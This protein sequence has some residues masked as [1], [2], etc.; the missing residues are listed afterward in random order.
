MN[1]GEIIRNLKEG[2][3]SITERTES[4]ITRI[5]Q[6]VESR[7]HLMLKR[8]RRKILRMMIE[9]VF[10][11][12]GIVLVIAGIVMFFIRF[13]PPDVV[14]VLAGIACLYIVMMLHWLK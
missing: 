6:M 1:L 14:L 10:L 12:L 9:A 7:I 5:S 11:G 8:I 2:F 13:F 3:E 4:H